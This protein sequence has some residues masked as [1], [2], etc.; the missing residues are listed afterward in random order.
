M[1]RIKILFVTN[2]PSPYRVDF[3]NELGKYCD[4]TIVYGGKTAKDR[5]EN[6][7]AN[8]AIN[9]REVYLKSIR[10]TNGLFFSPCVIHEFKNKYDYIILGGWTS[11]T[12]ILSILYL[13]IKRMKF[14]IEADGAFVKN[15]NFIKKM[16]KSFF[17]KSADFWLSSGK[18][19]NEYFIHYGAQAQRVFEY[20]FTSVLKKDIITHPLSN[21]KKCALREEFQLYDICKECKIIITVGSLIYRKGFDI[22]IDAMQYCS[23]KCELLIIGT[24]PT[25]EYLDLVK[26]L[27][28]QN[29]KFIN[30][31]PKEQLKRYYQLSDLFVLPT[32]EDIWGLVINE[33]MANGL[34]IIS[35]DKCIAALELV[36]ENGFI[37]P[38]E[39]ARE[40][41]DKINIFFS[42]SEKKQEYMAQKSLD[43]IKDYTIENMAAEHIRILKKVGEI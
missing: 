39:S 12:N 41:A 21:E 34:P 5:N 4:L 20:P 33:A 13:K 19:T 30:F 18:I 9:Y 14:G 15:D 28:L 3:F 6:W 23:Q 32:R 25:Q 2:I 27:G 10:V 17:I 40:L 1:H 35:T 11:P 8:N 16:I 29:I 31:M 43:V 36:K 7:K 24:N 42:Y 37:V 26:K 22:L 38:A